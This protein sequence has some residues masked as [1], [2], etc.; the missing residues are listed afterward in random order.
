M[1]PPGRQEGSTQS[2]GDTVLSQNENICTLADLQFS[3]CL[4]FGIP[5]REKICVWRLNAAIRTL[6]FIFT[7]INFIKIT[8]FIVTF[9]C[10]CI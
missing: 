5:F 8:G 3:L 6:F 7:S 1:E 10:I 4:V 2:G 9:L